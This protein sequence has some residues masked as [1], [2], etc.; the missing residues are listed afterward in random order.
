MQTLLSAEISAQPSVLARLR[1]SQGPRLLRLGADLAERRPRGLLIAA[2]GSSDH[3]AVYAQYLFGVRARL[4]VALAAP[5]L[6][7]VYDAAPRLDGWIVLA[8]S[9]SG[10]SPDV[11][12]VVAEARRQGA[13]SVALTDVASSDL[14]RVADEVVPLCVGGERAVAATGTF[15][16][17]LFALAHLVTGW[18]GA[19]ES[20][21]LAEVPDRVRAALAER[22]RAAQVARGL[23]SAELAYVIGRGFGFPVALEWALKLKEVAGLPAEPY[24]AADYRHGPIA[25]AAEGVPALLIDADGPARGDLTALAQQLRAR[26][27]RVVRT[28]DDG[29]GDLRFPAGP[30]WLAPIP[31][32][33]VGQL[34]ALELG[35]ARGR[36][37]DRPPGLTKITRT[38]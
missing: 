13:P 5:S 37:P 21:A 28:S 22:E 30:E 29:A 17:S 24:S 15:T 1:E 32:A 7:T 8:I 25:V 36:D 11:V 27:A 26:G 12:S 6:F 35:L 10:A 31:A 33:I 23:A 18:S 16:A 9:Q 38:R 34:L 3:A 20:R 19:D 2:R 14:A 4:A